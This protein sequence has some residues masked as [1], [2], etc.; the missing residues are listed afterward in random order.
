MLNKSI[1]DNFLSKTSDTYVHLNLTPAGGFAP[2][3]YFRTLFSTATSA[4]ST[5]I[6][7]K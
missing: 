7:F 5:A 1:Y 6:S 2:K 4:A 3:S